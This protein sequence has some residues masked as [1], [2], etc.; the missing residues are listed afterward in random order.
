MT[1]KIICC[2]QCHFHYEELAAFPYIPI[3]WRLR[4]RAEHW[5]LKRLMRRN[6]RRGD[7]LPM[8]AILAHA[9]EEM[10]VYRRHVP[11]DILARIEEDHDNV[12]EMWW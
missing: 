6:K 2:I 1:E 9:A 4:L 8:A 10:E 11:E 5:K 7:P 3:G 12:A